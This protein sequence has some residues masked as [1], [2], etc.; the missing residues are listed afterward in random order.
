[1]KINKRTSAR[2]WTLAITIIGGVIVSWIGNPGALFNERRIAFA[3]DPTGPTGDPSTRAKPVDLGVILPPKYI[4]NDVVLPPGIVLPG[5][6][7]PGIVLPPAGIVPP[8][9]LLP[10]SGVRAPVVPQSR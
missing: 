3:P 6:V 10:P 5:I 4:S 9:I 2:L 7:L 8:G 1:M